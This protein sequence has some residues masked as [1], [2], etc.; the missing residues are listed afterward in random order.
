MVASTFRKYFKKCETMYY[1]ASA[2][3]AKTSTGLLK[4]TFVS[5]LDLLHKAR[6]LNIATI[7]IRSL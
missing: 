7:V 2:K 6:I 5:N 3:R 1:C 4:A